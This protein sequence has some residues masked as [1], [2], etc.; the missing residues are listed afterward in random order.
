M[1]E[2]II[3]E[4][5]LTEQ[6]RRNPQQQPQSRMRT[7]FISYSSFAAKCRMPPTDITDMFS[8]Y[9]RQA[10][11]GLKVKSVCVMGVIAICIMN[12]GQCRWRCCSVLVFFLVR[13]LVNHHSLHSLFIFSLQSPVILPLLACP[14]LLLYCPSK[15]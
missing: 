6:T 3:T 9:S 14:F 11:C 7:L 15:E 12:G 10:K 13:W 2:L 5:A 8:V 1:S 4:G